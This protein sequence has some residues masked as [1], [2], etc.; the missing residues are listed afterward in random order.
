M[1]RYQKK[2]TEVVGCITKYTKAVLSVFLRDHLSELNEADAN[3]LR[4]YAESKGTKIDDASYSEALE[5]ER[6]CRAEIYR[7]QM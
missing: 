4:R 6:E 7:E 3:R 5:A 2:P 1:T